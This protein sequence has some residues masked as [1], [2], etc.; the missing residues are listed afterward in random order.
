MT[1]EPIRIAVRTF[2]ILRELSAD[3]V[4]LELRGGATIADAWE[5]MAGRHPNLRPH[6]EFV[7]A[8]RN[9]AY[10]AWEVVLADG[11]EVAFLPPVSGGARTGL[12]NGPIDVEELEAAMAGAEHGAL[13]TFV[14]R[15]RRH[16]DD[17]RE[18]VE[19]EYEVY[20]EMAEQVLAEIASESDDR[21][22][23]SSTAVVHRTGI[24]PLGEAAVV[25]VTAAVHRDEA[26]QANRHCIEAI[27]Q[28]LPIWK[29]ERFPDGSEWKRP[30]A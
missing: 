17:G 16:S 18:V 22:P 29:R 27:K 30:G 15:A 10:A 11:D 1:Q 4:S 9:G 6:R 25:I 13:V 23:G 12:S 19:L 5:E 24:V 14:G 2:A 26:Y 21:W 20:P 3:R 7:R 28:R 8:A